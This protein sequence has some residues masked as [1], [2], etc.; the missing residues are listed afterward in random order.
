[1]WELTL[2]SKTNCPL[3]DEA[4][5]AIEAF[6]Q[7]C[8]IELS[9]VDIAADKALWDKYKFDIPVLLIDGEEAARHHIGL[10]K[11]RVL[12]K[13]WERGEKP[14]APHSGLFPAV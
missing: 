12:R 2:L 8:E 3:C 4:K 13:R 14:L 1:M 5:V 11:L 7:E 6:A 9:V 10:K